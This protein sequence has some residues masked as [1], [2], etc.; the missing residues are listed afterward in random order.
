MFSISWQA[1]VLGLIVGIICLLG[2]STGLKLIL[3]NAPTDD[4][5]KPVNKGKIVIGAILLG[6]QL[7]V[8]LGLIYFTRRSI[9]SP[10]GI[11]LGLCVSIFIGSFFFKSFRVKK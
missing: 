5:D 9:N 1:I 8:A 2:L 6:G 7:L 10:L 11:A 3:E 4:S